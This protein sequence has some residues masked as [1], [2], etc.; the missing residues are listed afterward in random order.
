MGL[1]PGFDDLNTLESHSSSEISVVG[2]SANGLASGL[3][4]VPDAVIAARVP[5]ADTASEPGNSRLWYHAGI[6][7]LATYVLFLR[8]QSE[9]LPIVW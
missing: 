6:L 2:C 4:V 3:V 8:L 7:F 5:I 1:V 9:A